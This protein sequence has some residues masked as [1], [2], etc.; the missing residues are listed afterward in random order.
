MFNNKIL[1]LY[2]RARIA[3]EPSSIV[4]DRGSNSVETAIIVGLVAAAGAVLAGVMVTAI[5]SYQA[6]IPK[7]P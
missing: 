3:L 4:R 7:G 2:V 1:S 6:E 5:R